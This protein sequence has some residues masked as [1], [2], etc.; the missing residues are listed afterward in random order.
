VTKNCKIT[1]RRGDKEHQFS[2]NHSPPQ[3][4]PAI[5][6]AETPFLLKAS[7]IGFASSEGFPYKFN[8]QCK[9]HTECSATFI[10]V[11]SCNM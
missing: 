1:H 3:Q 2:E 10:Q 11:T 6:T 7:M 4:K 5:P 8:M 9:H